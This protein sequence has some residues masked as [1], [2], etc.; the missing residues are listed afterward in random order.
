MN[1]TLQLTR[2]S[3]LADAARTYQ[4]LLDGKVSGSIGNDG[5]T[6][7]SIAPGEHTLQIVVPKIVKIVKRHPA[8][9]SPTVTFEVDEGKSAKYVCHPP[10]YPQAAL[11][12]ITSQFGERDRWIELN[13]AR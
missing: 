7:M 12:W 2:S 3:R 5:R 11:S 1:A 8:L 6:E 4:V 10:S 13:P 9:S